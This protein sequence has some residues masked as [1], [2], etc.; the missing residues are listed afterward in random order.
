ME[1]ERDRQKKRQREGEREREI[2]GMYVQY[3]QGNDCVEKYEQVVEQADLTVQLRP[4]EFILKI[5]YESGSS[6]HVL[7]FFAR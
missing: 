4:R 2:P 3:K 5:S 1:R 6:E 7:D